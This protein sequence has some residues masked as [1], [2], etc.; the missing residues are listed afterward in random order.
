MPVAIVLVPESS[1]HQIITR[2]FALQQSSG[3][4][5]AALIA[6]SFTFYFMLCDEPAGR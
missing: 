4:L 2:I 1:A 5:E 6:L 3:V